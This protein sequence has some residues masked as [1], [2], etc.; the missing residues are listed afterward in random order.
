MKNKF[1]NEKCK[2]KHDLGRVKSPKKKQ[3]VCFPKKT[4]FLFYFILL[5]EKKHVFFFVLF[6]YR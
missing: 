6:H 2:E 1:V 5:F 3:A 4:C